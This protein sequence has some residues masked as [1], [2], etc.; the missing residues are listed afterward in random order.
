[1]I[2]MA[3]MRRRDDVAAPPLFAVVLAGWLVKRTMLGL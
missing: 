2:N 3:D 1:M